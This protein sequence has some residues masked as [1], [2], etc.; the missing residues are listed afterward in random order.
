M[1]KFSQR[2]LLL[3]LMLWWTF[4]VHELG[5]NKAAPDGSN[6]T[7]AGF[8]VLSLTLYCNEGLILNFLLI[9][10]KGNPVNM[11]NVWKFASPFH[12]N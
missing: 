11:F 7:A 2:C 4:H 3:K 10:S 8:R 5:Q 9:F 6:S 1:L 12:T